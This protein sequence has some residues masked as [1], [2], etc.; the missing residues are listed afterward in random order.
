MSCP[1]P[2]LDEVD[3]AGVVVWIDKMPE[4]SQ[5][6]DIH[7]IAQVERLLLVHKPG[8]C[9]CVSKVITQFAVGVLEEAALAGESTNQTGDLGILGEVIVP[10]TSVQAPGNAIGA[11]AAVWLLAWR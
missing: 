5:L 10:D 3:R 2:A 1:I 8:N 4:L 7:V 9:C 11:Y 6:I